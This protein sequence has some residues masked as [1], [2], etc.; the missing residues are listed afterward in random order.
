MQMRI[1]KGFLLLG[2]VGASLFSQ[3]ALADSSGIVLRL[4]YENGG[5][6][7]AFSEFD[8]GTDEELKAGGELYA[9][10]G[11]RGNLLG[12]DN[13]ETELTVGYK[14]GSIRAGNGDITFNRLTAGIAQYYRS[15][16]LRLGIG[17]TYH[18][19]PELELDFDAA[20]Q[21]SG[22]DKAT[23]DSAVGYMAMVD[24]ALSDR[25]E[26]G[27]RITDIEYTFNGPET[28]DGGVSK[29]AGSTGVFLNLL[30]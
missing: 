19:E 29:D 8:D 15:G 16:K 25:F 21:S 14:S 10:V 2:V 27:V 24:F 7:I 6:K 23:A 13:L 17:A 5:D 1:H 28:S 30:F 20:V 9:E 18:L 4:G 11:A 12:G 26:I 22:P 3:P